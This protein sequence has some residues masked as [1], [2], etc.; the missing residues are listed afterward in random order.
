[1]HGCVHPRR[2]DD[3]A[4]VLGVVHG[5]GDQHVREI[6]TGIFQHAGHVTL[7]FVVVE[8]VRHAVEVLD[9]IAT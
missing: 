2:I 3:I 5:V 9:V 8:G 4:A 6:V 7:A 1:M